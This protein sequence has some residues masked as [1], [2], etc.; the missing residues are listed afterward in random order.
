M[1]VKTFFMASI[2]ICAMTAFTQASTDFTALRQSAEQ[3]NT[4]A[5]FILGL[6]YDLGDGVP[7]DH[8]QAAVWYR[9][10]AEQ[11]HASAQSYLGACLLM[12]RECRR[13]TSR[14]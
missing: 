4:Q 5:Q 2:L 12:A 8:Q 3:E 9:K 14:R 11:G 1:K 7:Q 13:I 6:M 10:A